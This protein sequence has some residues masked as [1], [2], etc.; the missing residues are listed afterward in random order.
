LPAFGELLR[1]FTEWKLGKI[2]QQHGKYQICD[3][4][5]PPE[6]K[7]NVDLQGSLAWMAWMAGLVKLDRKATKEKMVK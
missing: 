3:L 1:L 6:T 2:K 7:A 4:Q 5:V